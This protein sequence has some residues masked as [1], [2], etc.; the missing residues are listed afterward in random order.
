MQR[1]LVHINAT[2]YKLISNYRKI[3]NS[4]SCVEMICVKTK[5]CVYSNHKHNFDWLI[6]I[7]L[8][9]LIVLEKYANAQKKYSLILK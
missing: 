8:R 1:Y 7:K 2:Y 6:L 5:N 9:K 4:E 3:Y